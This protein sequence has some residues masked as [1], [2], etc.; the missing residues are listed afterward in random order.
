MERKILNVGDIVSIK[1]KDNEGAGFSSNGL[2]VSIKR[3][4]HKTTRR[5][6]KIANLSNANVDSK[7]ITFL[8]ENKYVVPYQPFELTLDFNYSQGLNT[9]LWREKCPLQ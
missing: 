5:K 1:V 6:F 4:N 9:Y 8:L 2:Y 7:F 3:W